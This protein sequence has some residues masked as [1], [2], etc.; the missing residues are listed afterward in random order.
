MATVNKITVRQRDVLV[1][2]AE[3][4]TYV[5]IA[6]TLSI[7]AGTVNTHLANLYMRLQVHSR[8]QAVALWEEMNRRGLVR[9]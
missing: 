5:Q 9:K 7:G 6:E 4:K 8:S 3:G 2:L 1:L